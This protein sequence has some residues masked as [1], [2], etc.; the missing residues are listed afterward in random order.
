MKKEISKEEY[1]AII[2]EIIQCTTSLK[3]QI[4]EHTTNAITR[5]IDARIDLHSS[6]IKKME[7]TA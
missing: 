6:T 1:K 4:G 7:A 5:L 3:A 2:D